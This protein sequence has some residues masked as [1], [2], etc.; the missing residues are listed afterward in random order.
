VEGGVF[1]STDLIL[2]HDCVGVQSQPLARTLLER[3]EEQRNMTAATRT[4]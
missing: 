2:S 3:G 4:A 1:G